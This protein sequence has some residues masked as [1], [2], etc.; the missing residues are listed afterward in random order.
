MKAF[1]IKNEDKNGNI[2]YYC[3][4]YAKGKIPMWTKDP[5]NMM[6]VR[7]LN[8]ASAMMELK[9]LIMLGYRN[10]K[11]IGVELIPRGAMK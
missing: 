4:D 9:A 8:Q 10:L 11:I 6:V 3:G 1:I 2:F 7:F 5:N